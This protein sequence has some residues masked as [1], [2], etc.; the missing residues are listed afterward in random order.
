MK[1]IKTG[2][3]YTIYD[4]SIQTYDQLPP[5]TYAV[6][7]HQQEGCFLIRHADIEVN[8]KYY[9]VQNQKVEKVLESFREFSRN[10][11]RR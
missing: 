9:G 2:S 5:G 8:E 1:V 3:K 4:N 10:F 11:E 6:G 7:Y